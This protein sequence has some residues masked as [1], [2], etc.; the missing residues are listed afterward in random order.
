MKNFKYWLTAVIFSLIISVM[1]GMINPPEAQ[2]Q[3]G[4][5]LLK[6]G[7]RSADV[8]QLQN[9]LN[10][11][12]YDSGSADGIFGRRTL[13][14]VKN[15]QAAN[16]LTAD[17][18]AG[19]NTLR[20]LLNKTG[21]Y[22]TSP[23]RGYISAGGQD[24]KLLARLIYG[25]ARGESFEGQVAVAAVALNRYYSGKF[26]NSVRGVI[27]Q[28]GAFTAVSD[29]QYYLTPNATAYEAARAAL[30]GWDPTGSALYYWNPKTA[31]SKWIWSRPVIK[32]IGRHVF[33]R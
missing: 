2:A 19:A 31:T 12:G 14:A 30:N 10:Y 20:A 3:L 28:P 5:T 1:A 15:F 13:E 25:E 29:G 26:G 21:G 24:L 11:L 18:I 16:G 32:T 7:M 8:T 17:G 23:S 9:R 4:G 6:T 33:A 22:G 27:F